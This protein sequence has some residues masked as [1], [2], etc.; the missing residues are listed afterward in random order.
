MHS[1]KGVNTI[2][3]TLLLIMITFVI[4]STMYFWVTKMQAESRETTTQY[5]EKTLGNVITETKIVSDPVYN[6]L[7]EDNVCLPATLTFT[8][9][10]TGAK[11]IRIDN[12]S[13]ILVS[14]G[15]G[16]ICLNTFA[17]T[18]DDPEDRLYIGVQNGASNANISY[19]TDGSTWVQGDAAVG[20]SLLWK[21]TVYDKKIYYGSTYDGE[22]TELKGGQT[23]KSC[24]FNNWVVDTAF[25][26]SNIVHDLEVFNE[27]LYASTGSGTQTGI[28]YVK[29]NNATWGD[30]W[31]SEDKHIYALETFE[32]Y[33]YAGTTDNITR[34]SD[35]TT[36]T[37]VND[38]L[39]NISALYATSS[40]L[41]V[42][43]G[44]G[45]I[46][47]SSAG[48]L[49]ENTTLP[50]EYTSISAFEEFDGSLY[51][52]A[53]N[54]TNASILKLSGTTWSVVNNTK[55]DHIYD[56]ALFNNKIYASV[57][58]NDNAGVISSSDGTTW[59][60]AYANQNVT[61]I[62][63]YTYCNKEKVSC[64]R[65]CDSEL[66][67][68]ETRTL[69]LQLSNTDCDMTV[70]GTSTEYK[71]RIIFGSSA[72]IAGRFGKEQISSSNTNSR[73]EYTYP[74]CNGACT[75]GTCRAA[76]LGQICVCQQSEPCGSIDS[77]QEQC[78]IGNCDGGAC[79]LNIETLMCE[80]L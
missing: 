36:W 14:D 23:F 45:E 18:C 8:I 53:S 13:E 52:A 28:I 17:G 78:S 79:T 57:S 44:G 68:G 80:C 9:Q 54:N 20:T 70:F 56:F 15:N 7:A 46:W 3:A 11:K 75:I 25:I 47:R 66:V 35:G 71:F 39:G 59:T 65:G 77:Q 29:H 64:I 67:P 49:F 41:Y 60:Y 6:T 37:G 22:P 19:S 50:Y 55:A 21:G 2:V 72:Y 10:N 63:N 48:L 76:P 24:D 43:F 58:G 32:G 5:Q 4:A 73:C 74:F 1:K 33:L 42:G 40:Y 62:T 30:V 26:W 16:P 61:T 27:K 51:A 69:E 34:S 38:T 12:T 31:N